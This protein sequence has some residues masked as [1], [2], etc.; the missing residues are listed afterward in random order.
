[1]KIFKKITALAL[2]ACIGA[3]AAC[4]GGENNNEEKNN[5]NESKADEVELKIE[6]KR[7]FT[8]WDGNISISGSGICTDYDNLWISWG[9][10]DVK[11]SD[12]AGDYQV[13]KSSDEGIS[14]SEPKTYS[15]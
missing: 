9:L 12:I 6:R 2:T 13:T 15:P 4:G 14:F 8:V 3:L 1:M 11:N 10:M 7:I 5:M